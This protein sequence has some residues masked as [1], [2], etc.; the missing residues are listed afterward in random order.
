VDL[1]LR[2]S[3]ACATIVHSSFKPP[4]ASQTQDRRNG[5]RESPRK[6]PHRP[7]FGG[8]TSLASTSHGVVA[9]A[10]PPIRIVAPGACTYQLSRVEGNWGFEPIRGTA[11]VK[12]G[13]A[14]V[15]CAAQLPVKGDLEPRE[16]YPSGVEGSLDRFQVR[17]SPALE[18]L[19]RYWADIEAHAFGGA[20][21]YLVPG[22][23]ST[24]EVEFIASERHAR[25]RRVEFVG[26]HAVPVLGRRGCAPERVMIRVYSLV[27]NDGRFGCLAWSGSYEMLHERDGWRITH[28][29]LTPRR[30]E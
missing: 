27:T 15:G 1:P 26:K 9:I 3:L 10:D 21:R 25:I 22:A 24:T 7:V 29:A 17:V 18:V 2:T 4:F 19:E 6:Q 8:F 12:P 30:C 20:Y 16:F 14:G 28:A 5:N 23:I 13:S 11:T